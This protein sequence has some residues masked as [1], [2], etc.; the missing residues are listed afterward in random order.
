M[1][2]PV[3][4]CL[5]GAGV[6][7]VLL[8]AGLIWLH[9][10][11]RPIKVKLTGSPG[12][13]ISGRWDQDGVARSFR[14]TLPT[15]LVLRANHLSFELIR[16]AGSGPFKIE[17]TPTETDAGPMSCES[18]YGIRGNIRFDREQKQEDRLLVSF[19]K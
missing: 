9:G 3:L 2:N 17:L 14:A 6:L 4:R 18:D 5:I 11:A 13:V 8:A 19:G 15:E 12:L 1:K 7:S 16:E 10:K